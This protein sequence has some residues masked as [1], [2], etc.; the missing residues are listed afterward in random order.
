MSYILFNIVLLTAGA[1]SKN[2]PNP[3]PTYEFHIAGAVLRLRE[4]LIWVVAT[5]LMLALYFFVQRSKLGK[6]MRATG[7][8]PGSRA[9]M[10]GVEVDQVIITAFFLGSA[11]AGAGRHD[12]RAVL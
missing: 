9:R 3:L 8:G 5:L 10:M 6:A 1:D 4:I 7:A 11:L 2:F 12:L